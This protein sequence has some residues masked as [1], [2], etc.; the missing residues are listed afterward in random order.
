LFSAQRDYRNF[1]R[2]N[3]GQAGDEAS[4]QALRTLGALAQSLC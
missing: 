3:Y 2:L 4:E 1:I